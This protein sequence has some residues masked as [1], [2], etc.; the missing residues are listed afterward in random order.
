MKTVY[1]VNSGSYNDYHIDAL[2]STK[3]KAQEF[4]S[5]FKDKNYN[6]IEVF[7]LG[8]P[9]VSLAKRGYSVWMLLMQKDGTV[10]SANLT[11]NDKYYVTNIG[12]RIWWRS[13][14]PAYRGTDV[15]D[16]LDCKVWA[17]TQK[18]AVKSAN[19]KRLQM[20]ALGEW[21]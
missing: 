3:E 12:C 20:I 15:K 4:M 19:E 5:L 11:E 18:Q 7:Q 2:F 9:A 17:K 10:E 1:A 8:C 16:V 6:D 14:A 13:K 21:K